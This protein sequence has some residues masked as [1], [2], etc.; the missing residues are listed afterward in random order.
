MASGTPRSTPR[1]D[2]G[3]PPVGADVDL[4]TLPLTALIARLS[5][6]IV[7]EL[8]A[9]YHRH[10]LKTQPLD[11][12]LLILLDLG[13]A[14]MTAL[15]ER[16]HTSKQALT[17]VVDRLQR[18]GYLTRSPDPTDRRA[19]VL[20]LTPSGRHAARVTGA[21]MTELELRWRDRAGQ[22]QWP[23]ARAALA[24]IDGADTHETT[25]KRPTPR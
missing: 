10:Q 9:V 16:L 7:A 6:R 15:A 21:A 8:T 1:N 11:A 19:K 13:P 3:L 18:D 2:I 23:H 5:Q 20:T 22:D 14:R 12:S 24:R 25:G 17:F 4:G